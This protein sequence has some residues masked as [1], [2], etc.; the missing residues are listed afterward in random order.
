M[1]PENASNVA[2]QDK[3]QDNVELLKA[4]D[5]KLRSCFSLGNRLILASRGSK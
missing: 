4:Q 1:A 5:K 2:N 3:K